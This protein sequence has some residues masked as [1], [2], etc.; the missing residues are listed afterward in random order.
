MQNKQAVSK[1]QHD[2]DCFTSSTEESGRCVSASL[3]ASRW[4]NGKISFSLFEKEFESQRWSTTRVS[5]RCIFSLK[6]LKRG[7]RGKGKELYLNH[8]WVKRNALPL[9]WHGSSSGAIFLVGWR[10]KTEQSPDYRLPGSSCSHTAWAVRGTRRTSDDQR[11][12]AI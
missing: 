2:L 12:N 3:A 8:E 5:D 6:C 1:R 7:W 9:V 4:V 10:E 11:I